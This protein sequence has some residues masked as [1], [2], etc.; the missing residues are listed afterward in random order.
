MRHLLS[1][2]L[3]GV[4][5]LLLVQG[6]MA[7]VKDYTC[8]GVKKDQVE[9][10]KICRLRANIVIPEAYLLS[11]DDLIDSA[12]AA[13]VELHSKNDVQVIVVK[14]YPSE[15][16]AEFF[17][18]VLDM[19][20]APYKIGWDG[21]PASKWVAY[22]AETMPTEKDMFH[23]RT[24]MLE[25]AKNKETILERKQ[26]LAKQMKIPVDDV[27]FPIFRLVPCLMRNEG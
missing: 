16:Y 26:E 18:Q 19:T 27:Y 17:P 9:K 15:E 20:Y 8:V 2:A 1:V 11:K 13:A 4:I 5:V 10:T 12:K 22:I 3:S 23:I 24:W 14:L 7:E 21:K 25:Q 6:S